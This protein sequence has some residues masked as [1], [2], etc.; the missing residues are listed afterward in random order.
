MKSTIRL[1][2][3]LMVSLVIITT[4]IGCQPAA[5][6]TATSAVPTQPNLP[7][8]QPT[9][10]TPV[11]ETLVILS[12]ESFT[13]S[14][15][16]TNHTVLANWHLEGLVFDTLWEPDKTNASADFVPRLALSWKYLA[17]GVTLEIKLRPDIKFQDGS[18]FDAEDVVA[19]VGRYSDPT[20]PMGFF[21]AEQM[22][23]T[24]VDPLTVDLKTKSGQPYAPL[25]NN[26]SWIHI[27]SS[28]DI[29]NEENL[30][31]N[32]NGTGPYKFVSYENEEAKLVANEN[33]WDKVPQI[34]NV[35]YR[36]VADPSTRLAAL[37]SGEADLIERV[38]PD[39][40][41]T[42]TSDPNLE[43]NSMPSNETKNLVFKWQVPPMQEV[44]V[45]QAIAYAIDRETIVKDIL[46]GNGTV[47]DSFVASTVWGYAPA[48]GFP[49]YDPEKAK[50][51][52]VQAGYP[53]GVGLPELTY[54]TSVGF[55]PKTK[56]YG[57]FIVSNLAD[58]GI[59][60]KLVPME[61]ASW[62]SALYSPTPGNMVDTGWMN[63][64]P[65]PDVTLASLYKNPGLTT[66]GGSAEINDAL[67]NES[68]MVDPVKRAAYLKDV[69]YPKIAQLMPQLPL[70]NSMLVYAK[71]KDLLG[72]SPTSTSDMSSIRNAY[73]VS[74]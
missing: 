31:T 26:L 2:S 56:E 3:L 57:E 4:L 35:I 21:W 46:Q 50:A 23:G 8:E 62:L 20:K 63:V 7:T 16:P 73:F 36:Y 43:I 70:F 74:K 64:G 24:V 48:K 33:Y 25:I 58:V 44:L 18:N 10:A 14:W 17:D 42:I 27:M 32:M 19:S 54:L 28:T 9:R 41:P 22:V 12:A 51:L 13:G 34:K 68:R 53:N 6:P 40:I 29:A 47:A 11:K 39:Q 67:L 61:T 71:N 30:K 38:D 55:Y 5:T 49:I 72:F 1:F 66:G 45:R 69:V 59:K 37:Q 60:C 65:D 52:L 15:D